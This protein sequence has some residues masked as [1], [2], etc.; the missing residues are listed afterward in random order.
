VKKGRKPKETKNSFCI[1]RVLIESIDDSLADRIKRETREKIQ[2]K[3]AERG[4]NLAGE[5]LEQ[6]KEWLEVKIESEISKEIEKAHTYHFNLQNYRIGN[7]EKH[8]EYPLVKLENFLIDIS[9]ERQFEIKDDKI[10]C[11]P[12]ISTKTN[13]C[14]R[15]N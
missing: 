10:Y 8:T 6:F 13:I 7:E 11:E 4:K 3:E 15:K 2:R 9:N 5:K 14:E 1:D 12:T